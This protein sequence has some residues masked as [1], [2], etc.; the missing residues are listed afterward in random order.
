[1]VI[2]KIFLNPICRITDPDPVTTM[3]VFKMN[4]FATFQLDSALHMRFI[5]TLMTTVDYV[6]TKDQTRCELLV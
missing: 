2:Y 5:I 6:S 1:L 3:V 4:H